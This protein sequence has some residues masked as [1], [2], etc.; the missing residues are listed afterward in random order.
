MLSILSN[1][2]WP[3]VCPL[4]RSVCPGPLPIFWLDHLFLSCMSS[5][6]ILDIRPLLEVLLANIFSH[7]DG[8]LFTLVVWLQI[9]TATMENSI[10][11]LQKTKNWSTIWSNNPSTGY[12]PQRL[13]NPYP[14]RYLHTNVHSSI[15]HSGQ[16]MEATKVSYNR[17]LAKELLVHISNGILLSHKKDEILS[18]AATWMDLK[19]IMLS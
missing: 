15:I 14:K 8:S 17:W 18:F 3:F 5:L 19:I 10:E 7:S 12:L 6:Y 13:E 9:G 2:C 16:D 1:I 11:V 4:G